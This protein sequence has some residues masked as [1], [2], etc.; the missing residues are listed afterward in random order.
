M[1]EPEGQGQVLIEKGEVPPEQLKEIEAGEFMTPG[2][3]ADKLRYSYQW[4]LWM[5]QDGRV[6]GIKPLGSRWRIARS[7]YERILKEGIPLLPRD[8]AQALKPPVTEIHIDEKKVMDKVREP[9]KKGSRP[10]SLW[11]FDFTGIFG[12]PKK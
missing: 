5:L 12:Q 8:V 6:K 11:P 9:K 2:E 3:V 1:E 7:E 10:P 4:V